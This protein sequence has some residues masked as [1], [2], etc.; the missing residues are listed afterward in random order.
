MQKE[1]ED[2]EFTRFLRQK[3]IKEKIL[4]TL[5]AIL[6]SMAE[7]VN[8]SNGNGIIL[9][10]NPAFDALFGYN[11]G[12]LIGNHLSDL[13]TYS[14]EENMQLF[15]QVRRIVDENRVWSGELRCRKKDGTEFDAET[16]INGVEI[17]SKRCLI[18]V[19][20]DITERKSREKALL[21]SETKHRIVSQNT[22]DWIFW[23]GPERKFLYMSPACKRISGYDSE[24]FLADPDLLYRIIHPDDKP[25]FF[26]QQ[27]EAKS[28]VHA[29]EIEF[30]IIHKDGTVRWI[31]HV[32]QAI[33]D[34]NGK[35]SGKH[36]SNRDITKRKLAENEVKKTTE[37][38][39]SSHIKVQTT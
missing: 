9:Y 35:F 16:R 27:E 10:T 28:H 18:S 25:T 32:C 20:S 12:E 13:T 8:V 26:R 22:C 29:E 30:R 1:F 38:M 4:R 15:E 33:F 7:G 5:S 14:L 11:Q 36:A 34:N 3:K 17:G 37:S 31:G 21:E 2:I 23:M 39:S 19:Q 24:E 6:E